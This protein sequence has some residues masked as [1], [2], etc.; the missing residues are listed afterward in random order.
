MRH[1]LLIVQPSH[2]R[3]KQ[4]RTIFR[5]RRRPVVSL[6]LPYLAAL[7]PPDWDV[8]LVDEHLQD[9]DF[10]AR[11]DLV[12]ISTWTVTSLRAYDVAAEFRRR[13]V[14]VII[15]GPHIYFHAD[16]AQPHCDAVG[17]G[18]GE[19]IWRQMLADAVNG[20]LKPVYRG[21][22]V[23]DLGG[24]PLPRYD[25][26]N[27][28]QYGPV[29]TF[30][31]QASRGCPF[32]CEFCSERFYLGPSYRTRPVAE[33]VEEVRRC[34]AKNFLFV[35]SNFGGKRSHGLE[36]ME[37][38]IPLKLRWSALWT[39]YLCNDDEFMDLAKR[40]GLLHVNLG[41][42][43][44]DPLTLDAMNK[45]FNKVSKYEEMMN[46]LRRR[47]ISYSMNFI[48]GWDGESPEVFDATFAF[49]EQ[50]RVPVAH[51]NLLTPGKGTPLYDRMKAEGRLL[52]A[53]EIDRWPGNICYFKPTHGT[54][55]EL[56]RRVDG[57]YRRF[58]SLGSIVRRLPLPVT[59]ARIASWVINLT[60]RYMGIR[61]NSFDAF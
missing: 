50:H 60:Q 6:T 51:F 11:V 12:A 4:D 54:P 55:E 56:E 19:S 2:Y 48:F 16:E 37:A 26:L 29:K 49:L 52:N 35:D 44:I 41:I 3:S 13:K 58:Y 61:N 21:E 42:E 22:V 9:I 39:S 14:P 30:A 53:D 45:R 59:Q 20:G 25:L 40:S 33:V 27:L 43:S 24:L 34:G 8:S 5:I 47:G 31:V 57:M 1:R 23:K 38:L 28:R 18:E 7:T 10:D 32:R 46:S 17:I 36:L 15:G